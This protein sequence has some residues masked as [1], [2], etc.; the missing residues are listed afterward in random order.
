MK[1]LVQGA[2]VAQSV[3]RR[4]LDSSSGHD[5]TVGEFEPLLGL[6]ADRKSVV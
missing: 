1:G 2:W 3:K 5:L 6:G 4:T